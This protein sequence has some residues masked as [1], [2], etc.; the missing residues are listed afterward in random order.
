MTCRSSRRNWCALPGTFVLTLFVI[1][2]RT[3]LCDRAIADAHVHRKSDNSFSLQM[4]GVC[5]RQYTDGGVLIS[6]KPRQM[7]IHPSGMCSVS[8]AFCD[9]EAHVRSPTRTLCVDA[10][11]FVLCA[12][13]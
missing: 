1:Q 10:I 13:R 5:I 4:L 11:A 8:T 9:I 3:A 2:H 12:C 6:S 7:R